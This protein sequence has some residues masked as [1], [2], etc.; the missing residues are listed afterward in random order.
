M[1]DGEVIPVREE[2]DLFRLAGVPWTE[3][4]NRNL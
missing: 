1:R 3:P 4:E 2:A